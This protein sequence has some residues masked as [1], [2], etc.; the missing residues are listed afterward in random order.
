MSAPMPTTDYDVAIVGYG[1]VGQALAALLGQHGWRVGV[2][3]RWPTLYPL[4]RA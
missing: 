3:E 1:P 2:F 4:P